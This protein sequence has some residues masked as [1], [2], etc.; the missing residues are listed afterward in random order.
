MG[1]V[2]TSD[3][4]RIRQGKKEFDPGK[5]P[6]FDELPSVRKNNYVK[7]WNGFVKKE[8]YELM[9]DNIKLWEFI[10]RNP[11]SI[12]SRMYRSQAV[13][14]EKAENEKRITEIRTLERRAIQYVRDKSQ[15][16][17]NLI[18]NTY[19]FQKNNSSWCFYVFSEFSSEEISKTTKMVSLLPWDNRRIITDLIVQELSWHI[20]PS[21]ISEYLNHWALIGEY[22][23]SA[24]DSGIVSIRT[25]LPIVKNPSWSVG[26]WVN[27]VLKPTPG[28]SFKFDRVEFLKFKQENDHMVPEGQIWVKTWSMYQKYP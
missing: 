28:S 3:C 1:I 6:S 5:Y 21:D 17:L 25:M 22:T 19:Y 8:A 20:N 27:I 9:K 7:W 23:D 4:L 13:E 14:D 18:L 16:F 2:T 11:I 15:L 12:S 26:I 10:M 24:N